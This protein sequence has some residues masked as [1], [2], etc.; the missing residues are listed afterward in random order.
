MHV[1]M[2]RHLPALTALLLACIA[3]SILALSSSETS[4]PSIALSTSC[5]KSS[6]AAAE[7]PIP[8]KESKNTQ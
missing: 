3:D 2:R 8:P 7:M 1:C 5:R 4:F 6:D